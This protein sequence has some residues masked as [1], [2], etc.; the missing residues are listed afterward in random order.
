MTTHAPDFRLPAVAVGPSAMPLLGLGTWRKPALR[1]GVASMVGAAMLPSVIAAA[2]RPSATRADA[3]HLRFYGELAAAQ[4]PQQSFPA[5]T[6]LLVMNGLVGF[7]APGLFPRVRS[8]LVE[9]L[10]GYG[11]Q[12]EHGTDGFVVPAGVLGQADEELVGEH[13]V[14]QVRVGREPL[15][16]LVARS[17]GG[18]GPP[19][20]GGLE[21]V[22]VVAESPV[23][24]L[25][26]ATVAREPEPL[27]QAEGGQLVE[28]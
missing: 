23:P 26:A 15:H 1:T 17:G 13:E 8:R 24:W 27:D 6:V 16:G 2:L 19:V 4:D 7:I 9:T 12:P 18:L 28:A 14:G 21:A 11:T 5:P 22:S 10:A 25:A 20:R 3:E